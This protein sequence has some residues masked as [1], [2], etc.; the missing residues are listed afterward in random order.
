MTVT[1][2]RV[3]AVCCRAIKIRSAASLCMQQ[4]E[5]F[6][7][8][9]VLPFSLLVLVHQLK[10]RALFVEFDITIHTAKHPTVDSA[11]Q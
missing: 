4:P 11:R 8:H 9:T 10:E 3:S 7:T 6:W 5:A 1:N 2:Y